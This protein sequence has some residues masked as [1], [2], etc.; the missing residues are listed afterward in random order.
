[1]PNGRCLHW[2]ESQIRAEMDRKNAEILHEQQFGVKSLA[3]RWR[4][5]S[6]KVINAMVS[7]RIRSIMADNFLSAILTVQKGAVRF[8]RIK[9][10]R[11]ARAR[12]WAK[13]HAAA[14]K[15]QALVRGITDRQYATFVGKC[16]PFLDRNANVF[17]THKA[18]VRAKRVYTGTIEPP[19]TATAFAF[20]QALQARDLH[21]LDAVGKLRVPLL[22]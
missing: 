4:R 13:L 5:L 16:K 2:T 11:D 10:A 9:R 17:A 7:K 14:T 21:S 3:Y 6:V 15:I 19:A 18:F 12:Q 22:Q 20:M 8:L 1:M